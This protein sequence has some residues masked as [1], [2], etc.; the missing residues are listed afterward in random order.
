MGG[1]LPVDGKKVIEYRITLGTK[2]RQI[3]EDIS[4][5]LRIK[6]LDPKAI[7]ETL[8]DPTKIIQIAYS[9]ATI[10]ELFGIETGLPTA[11]DLPEVYEW[12]AKRGILSSQPRSEDNPSIFDLLKNLLSGEY[13]GI[14]G[15]Y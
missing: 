11:G 9:I 13:G 5:S 1:R 3:A 12:F 14:R 15:G 10:A 2:E 6:S 7:I 4:T 8:D